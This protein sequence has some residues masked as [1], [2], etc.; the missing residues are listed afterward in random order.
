MRFLLYLCELLRHHCGCAALD[1]DT[2]SASNIATVVPCTVVRTSD[3]ITRLGLTRID[4]LKVDVEGDELEARVRRCNNMACFTRMFFQAMGSP[5]PPKCQ[6]LYWMSV[7]K[8]R[9]CDFRG[10]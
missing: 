7:S 1:V 8:L 10:V 2:V 5:L 9:M 6:Y 3:A 4:L